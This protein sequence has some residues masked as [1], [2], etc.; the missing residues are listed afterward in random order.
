MR[1]EVERFI[2]WALHVRGKQ[3]SQ[4]GVM[5]VRA[6]LRFLQDPQPA[7]VW[8]SAIKRPRQHPDCG[9]LPAR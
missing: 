4:V 5:D 6:Y 8:V 9:S 2:L 3:L 7:A 1:K